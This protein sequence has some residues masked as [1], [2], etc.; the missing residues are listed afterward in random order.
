MIGL[1]SMG[2]SP[3][4]AAT[5]SILIDT[6]PTTFLTNKNASLVV[7]QGTTED[8]LKTKSA[9]MPNLNLG[10]E[11][12]QPKWRVAVTAGAGRMFVE[13]DFEADVSQADIGVFYRVSDAVTIG[14]HLGVLYIDPDYYGADLAMGDAAA[15]VPGVSFV[16]GG[17]GANFKMSLDYLS[18][19]DIA[20]TGSN[21]TT[22]TD[23]EGNLVD[24][25][26]MDGWIFRIGMVIRMHLH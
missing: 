19:A 6:A 10:Y 14:P 18:G 5:H 11:F 24:E 3:V 12:N 7:K 4:L 8:E 2:M 1:L 17:R 9:I 23:T 16:A 21:G 15:V 20:L 13:P 22:V 26:T 25:L